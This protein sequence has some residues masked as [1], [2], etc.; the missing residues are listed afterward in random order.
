MN[1]HAHYA[2][3]QW[4]GAVDLYGRIYQAVAEEP[5]ADRETI[6]RKQEEN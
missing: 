4:V 2:L 3:K 6:F 5:E 1:G